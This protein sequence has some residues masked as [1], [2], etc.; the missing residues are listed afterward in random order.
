[1][2]DSIGLNM[3]LYRDNGAENGNCHLGFR[4]IPICLWQPSGMVK[5]GQEQATKPASSRQVYKPRQQMRQASV[6]EDFLY[7]AQGLYD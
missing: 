7:E 5:E 3:R 1:M 2:W 4:H 6:R